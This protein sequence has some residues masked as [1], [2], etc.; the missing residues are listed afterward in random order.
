V[1]EFT[2][3]LNDSELEFEPVRADPQLALMLPPTARFDRKDY[4][5]HLAPIPVHCFFN[6]IA[7]CHW[8]SG[9]HGLAETDAFVVYL[10]HDMFKAL[11]NVNQKGNWPHSR[12]LFD[13]LP[14]GFTKLHLDNPTLTFETTRNHH[15]PGTTWKEVT[16]HEERLMAG[17]ESRNKAQYRWDWPMI[18]LTVRLQSALSNALSIAYIKRLFMESY[19][20]AVRAE[21]PAIFARFDVI[22]YQY[23]FVDPET[24]TGNE[25]Q[26]IE[27]LCRLSSVE[28]DG[29]RLVIHT[30]IG[31]HGIHWTPAQKTIVRLPFWLLLTLRE[32]PT[33]LL[34]PVPALY[35][36][37]GQPADN[38]D[39]VARV[40]DCFCTRVQDLL[41]AADVSADKRARWNA[42]VANI[43]AGIDSV[44]NVVHTTDFDQAVDAR[45]V[46]S[47]QAA[48]ACSMC[49]SPI[50]PSFACSPVTDLGAN[51][52]NYTDWHLGDAAHTCVLCA[53]SHF[54]APS[55]LEPARDL[56]F[57]RKLVY[58]STSTPFARKTDEDS[59]H[60]PFVTVPAFAPKLGIQS[61][62]SL[63]T[64]NIVAALY[65][66]D[67]VRRAVYSRN[68]EPALWLQ[69][70][71][72][73]GP[74]TFAGEV[75][76]AQSKTGMSDFLAELCKSMSR[77]V[78][79]LDPLLPVSVE[80]PVHALVCLWGVSKGRHFQLKYK[81]LIVS[82]ETATLPIIWDGYHLVDQ[83]TLAAIHA[84]ESLVAAFKHPKISNRMK[85]TAL[86]SSPTEFI[87]TLVELGGFNYETVVSRLTQVSSDKD[88]QRYLNDLS[89][90][91][92]RMPILTEIWG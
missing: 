46:D 8:L 58:F 81:P 47:F 87:D 65:L 20:E 40:R 53:I 83:D 76:K 31:A 34:F 16:A 25:Q 70:I 78:V 64:L 13:Y 67:S 50:P 22:S 32:D 75:A 15:V 48:A 86:A 52:S 54:K 45:R 23:D 30:F 28:L 5:V 24:L 4:V 57:Q 35:G 6:G 91:I 88:V 38:P 51:V 37:T 85:V 9:A 89:A 21:Y 41:L 84:I 19:V 12:E 59:A 26:D 11:L 10:L 80:V 72:S 36:P 44:F 61:L 42:R 79:L 66:H 49:G 2:I 1:I 62:E 17:V 68:G 90:L 69:S 33:S 29:R 55:A 60:L 82:N 39:F 18:G 14:L 74:F 27:M 3:S 7:L 77:V 56:I 43:M 92:A 63:V 71:F 73:T